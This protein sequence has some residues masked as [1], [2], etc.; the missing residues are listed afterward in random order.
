MSESHAGTSLEIS[1]SRVCR[2]T[3]GQLLFS[4]VTENPRRRGSV[5]DPNQDIHLLREVFPFGKFLFQL[6]SNYQFDILV[7][8][9][10]PPFLIGIFL[11]EIT[12]HYR[13]FSALT[14]CFY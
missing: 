1:F 10:K 11:D 9:E 14:K 3:G 7:V 5:C 4:C 13:D 12:N 8:H 2:Q 6:F